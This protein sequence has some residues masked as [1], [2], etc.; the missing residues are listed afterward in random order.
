METQ[1]H[2]QSAQARLPRAFSLLTFDALDSVAEEAASHARAGAAEGTL[3]QAA[4]SRDT[5]RYGIESAAR[6][7]NLYAALILRPEG[8]A[9]WAAELGLLGAVSL[10]RALAEV[11]EPPAEL[12]YSWPNRLRL[13]QG[14]VAAVDLLGARTAAGT[15]DW[16]ALSLAVNVLAPAPA[17][18]LEGAGL[19]REGGS[20][21][22]A[23]DVLER[24]A[25]QFLSAVDRWS[26]EGLGATVRHWTSRADFQ[27]PYGAARHMPLCG[28]YHGLDDAGSLLLR[29]AEGIRQVSLED[30]YFGGSQVSAPGTGVFARRPDGTL[31]RVHAY[32]D[33]DYGLEDVAEAFQ[34][35]RLASA[36]GGVVTLRLSRRE[37]G[38]LKMMADAYSFDHEA[39]FIEMCLDIVRFGTSAAE[40]PLHLEAN[41]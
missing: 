21:A 5:H 41:F 1:L 31:H 3:L 34:L 27:S 17:D 39:G 33:G 23:A 37:L 18:A 8:P 19:A 13:N 15:V 4:L 25:R 24:F 12:H 32:E 30:I 29:T 26:D 38:Q 7:G 28:D 10:G 22:N 35:G 14:N 20:N 36:A 6:A 11:V 40:D 16:V 2:K 9:P